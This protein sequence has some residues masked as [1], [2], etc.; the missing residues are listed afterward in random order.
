MIMKSHYQLT[1]C[2]NTVNTVQYWLS[3]WALQLT[4]FFSI[5]QLIY[6]ETKR[7]VF[8]NW[9]ETEP[10]VF[11]KTE[12]NLK[13]PFRTSLEVVA[14]TTAEITRHN[15]SE[16]YCSYYSHT[17]VLCVDLYSKEYTVTATTALLCNTRLQ[18]SRLF[19]V[20]VSSA[21]AT[22]TRTLELASLWTDIRSTN[23]VTVHIVISL[24]LCW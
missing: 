23:T 22:A 14:R 12:P 13:N 6:K 7:T 3:N 9:T 18:C 1:P 21:G 17:T 16:Q 4:C 8:Q 19:L 15:T 24:G 20:L 11:L 2:N 5:L 10:V